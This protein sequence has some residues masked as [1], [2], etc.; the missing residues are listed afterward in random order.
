MDALRQVCLVFNAGKTKI[1]T[2]QGQHSTKFVSPSGIAVEILARDRAQKWLGCMRSTQTDGSHGL[3]LEHHLHPASR[4]FYANKSILCAK[5]VSISHRLADFDA[6]VTPVA[7]FAGG[8]RKIYKQDLPKFD[9]KFRKVRMI[10]G[11]PHGMR[12]F[13]SGMHAYGNVPNKL[14]SSYGPRDAW[15]NIRS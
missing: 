5:S 12:S 13:M 14:A 4:A 2:M 3:D 15:N 9:I 1:L 6:M 11:L 8:H 10:V 7:C